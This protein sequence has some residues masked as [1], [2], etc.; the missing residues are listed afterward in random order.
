MVPGQFTINPV[1]W[2]T[3]LGSDAAW[4]VGQGH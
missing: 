1:N 4:A 3:D 2:P